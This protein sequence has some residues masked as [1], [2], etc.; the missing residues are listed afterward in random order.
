MPAPTQTVIRTLDETNAPKVCEL[1]RKIYQETFPFPEVYDP[2]LLLE[3]TRKHRKAHLLAFQGEELLGQVIVTPAPWNPELFEVAGFMTTPEA[4]GKNVTRPLARALRKEVF[5]SLSWKAR[6]S[7]SVTAHVI[8]QKGDIFLGNTHTA[9]ALNLLPSELFLHDPRLCSSSRGSCILSFG[10]ANSSPERTLLPPQYAP[11]LRELA[12]GFL[13]RTFQE[14]CSSPEGE[15][16]LQAFPFPAAGAVYLSA[17]RLGEDFDPQLDRLLEEHE[18]HEALML[19]LPL[20]R[21]IAK[22]VECAQRRGFSLGGFLPHWFT[23]GD[24]MLLQRVKGEPLWEEIQVL[25]G[26]GTALLEMVRQDWEKTFSAEYRKGGEISF[27][28]R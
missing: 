14:D 24:G 19:Q 13:P 3:N 4:Q 16:I 18:H 27:Q 1:Y 7:E 20:H 6:Y 23:S 21:G 11:Q 17:S 5:P 22:A 15:S 28:V 9:L 8:S 2:V 10:E 26:R 25:P 12:E